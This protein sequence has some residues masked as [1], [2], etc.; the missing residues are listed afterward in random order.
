MSN[1]NSAGGSA[2][3][4]LREKDPNHNVFFIK[5]GSRDTTQLI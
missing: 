4:V 1:V 2:H 3:A 5:R